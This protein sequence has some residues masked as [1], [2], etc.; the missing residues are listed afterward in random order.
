MQ[1][2]VKSS[3]FGATH[4]QSQELETVSEELLHDPDSAQQSP[5]E[6]AIDVECSAAQQH[7]QLPPVVAQESAAHGRINSG[8]SV[9]SA[10]RSE[11]LPRKSSAERLLPS[12]RQPSTTSRC[13][14]SYGHT[15]CA[16]SSQHAAS[17]QSR[18]NPARRPSKLVC[19]ICLKDK[20]YIRMVLKY[21]LN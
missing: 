21:E 12:S 11:Y 3:L 2:G 17:V 16:R 10:A 20:N 6:V 18:F 4:H 9:G 14:S 1:R 13:R 15:G 8:R 5:P 7:E 19:I